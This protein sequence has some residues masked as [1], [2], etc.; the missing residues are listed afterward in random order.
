MLVRLVFCIC[1]ITHAVSVLLLVVG[2]CLNGII[3]VRA[4]VPYTVCL[5]NHHMI[6]LNGQPHIHCVVPLAVIYVHV[7]GER[8][9]LDALVLYVICTGL[10]YVTEITLGVVVSV[11]EHTPLLHCGSKRQ[12][13]AAVGIYAPYLG[14]GCN[15]VV[16]VQLY[17]CHLL[18]GG[19]ITYL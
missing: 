11:I 6:H 12:C 17:Y 8:I 15:L 10:A 4:A 7:D 14:F 13:V 3:H 9:C 5:V 18:L 16:A 1:G 2:R 19:S